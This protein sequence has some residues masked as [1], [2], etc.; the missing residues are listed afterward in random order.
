MRRHTDAEGRAWDVLVGRESFGA[1][2][3]LF[4]PAE[5]NPGDVRQALL[6][7]ASQAEADAELDALSTGELNEL[8]RESEPKRLQ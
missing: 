3:A 5:G 1:M 4:V 2:Y 6:S 7:A 8:L